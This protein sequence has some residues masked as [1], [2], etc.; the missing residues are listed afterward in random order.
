[1]K[2]LTNKDKYLA[3]WVLFIVFFIDFIL[4][5]VSDTITYG[6]FDIF[7][8]IGLMMWPIISGLFVWHYRGLILH[9]RRKKL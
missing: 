4:L 7:Y 6:E 9:G 3:S 8:S 2:I 1:M 5:S